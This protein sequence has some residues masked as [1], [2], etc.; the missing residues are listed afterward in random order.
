MTLCPVSRS[1]F[2]LWSEGSIIRGRS[3]LSPENSLL[4]EKYPFL[5]SKTCSLHF[6]GNFLPVTLRLSDVSG[7]GSPTSRGVPSQFRTNTYNLT[8]LRCH[9]IRRH[10]TFSMIERYKPRIEVHAYKTFDLKKRCHP[11]L[12]EQNMYVGW[13]SDH[14][15]IWRSRNNSI[16]RPSFFFFEGDHQTIWS[17]GP[18]V[19]SGR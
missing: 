1:C 8:T 19:S 5:S 17:G 3:G 10:I 15:T 16:I 18:Y 2:S 4:R 14:H 11:L 13:N 9:R 6:C 12:L 7:H